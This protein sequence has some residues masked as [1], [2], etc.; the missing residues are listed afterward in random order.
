MVFQSIHNPDQLAETAK[1]IRADVI[2]ML[3]EAGSG[4]PGGSLSAADIVTTLLFSVMR[5]DP[6]NPLWPD[7]DRFVMSKGH[8]IPVW[9][10]AMAQA[11]YLPS[12]ELLNLRRLGSRL[13]GHPDRVRFPG[14]EAST[15]SLGQGLS[16]ALG[17]ALVAQMDRAPWRVYSVLGDGEI[18]EGQI[19]EAAMAAG[20]FGVDTLCATLDYNKGQIDGFVKDVMPLEP[21]ADKWRAFHWNVIEV[22][23][24][25]IT[26][27]QAAYRLAQETKGKPTLVLADT[28]K[29]KGVDFMEGI[30]DWHGKAPTPEQRDQALAILED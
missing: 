25:D 17:M 8:A 16:L 22:D 4:H 5:H 2:R 29:G 26:A 11:G 14:I 3:A 6:Q 19:W 10:A 20:K 18:Q 23:G 15:G 27:L 28:I 21:I 1:R 9:Y 24:H 7:R 12:E 30:I 13:Q